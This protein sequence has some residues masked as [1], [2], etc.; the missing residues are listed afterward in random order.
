MMKII[1]RM[2]AI[3][4]QRQVSQSG[5]ASHPPPP[6]STLD[7]LSFGPRDF[8]K[9]GPVVLLQAERGQLKSRR[10]SQG[11]HETVIE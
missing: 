10:L 9:P 8:L 5:Q 4:I 2:T 6:D 1:A 11:D 7:L 3:G